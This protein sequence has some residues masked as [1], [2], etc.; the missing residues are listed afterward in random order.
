MVQNRDGNWFTL[1]SF[2]ITVLYVEDPM[3]RE[4]EIKNPEFKTSHVFT[5]RACDKLLADEV[6]LLME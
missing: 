4:D 2:A 6:E 1:K 5:N 3:Q